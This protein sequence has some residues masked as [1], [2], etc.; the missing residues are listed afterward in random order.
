MTVIWM[1]HFSPLCTL[2]RVHAANSSVC[3]LVIVA[4]L[5][6][7]QYHNQAN[8]VAI[9]MMGVAS[10]GVRLTGTQTN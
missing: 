10:H 1:K 9:A 8:Y 5:N 7:V 3:P 2:V 6:L 4:P